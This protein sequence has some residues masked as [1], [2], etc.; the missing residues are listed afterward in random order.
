M[1]HA[2]VSLGIGATLVYG[3]VATAQGPPPP[4]KFTDAR[5]GY[6]YDVVTIGKARWFAENLRFKTPDSRCYEGDEANC[7]DHGRLY[8]L[9]DA[10]QACPSWLAGALGGGLARAG[11]RP[12]NV[13]GGDPEGERPRRSGGQAPQVRRRH[14]DS[15]S[16]TRDGSIPTS[17]TAP[18]PWAATRPTGPRP[19]ARRTTSRQ[20]RG[21]GTSPPTGTRS[22]VR[23]ST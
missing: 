21:I 1:P 18:R 22:G 20:R 3:L 11:A 10:L 19:P 8:R 23:R 14:A 2:T 12:G 15:T 16:A 4:D 5:D 6:A 7:V 17:R 13:G 9:Q